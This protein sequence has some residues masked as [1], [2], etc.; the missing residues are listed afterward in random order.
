MRCT[1]P[2]SWEWEM[3]SWC[4][5]L[6]LSEISGRSTRF[7]EVSRRITCGCE[8]RLKTSSHQARPLLPPTSSARSPSSASARSPSSASFDHEKQPDRGEHGGKHENDTEKQPR[9]HHL[10]EKRVG[11]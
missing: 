5:V 2:C 8:E 7:N 4:G 11:G 10:V 3:A 1:R 6:S 9:V